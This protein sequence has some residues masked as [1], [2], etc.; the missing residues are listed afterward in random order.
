MKFACP[1]GPYFWLINAMIPAIAGEEAE[2][3][4][5]MPMLRSPPET[6]Q[7]YVEAQIG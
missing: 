3:P 7:S 4:P 5:T 6:M 1:C 2:V